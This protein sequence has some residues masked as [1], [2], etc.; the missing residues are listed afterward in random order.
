MNSIKTISS[1][2]N[3]YIKFIRSLRTKKSRNQSGMFYIEG[4]RLVGEA[5]DT[6][7]PLECVLFCP[8]LL[9]SDYGKDLVNKASS[10]NIELIEVTTE[11]FHYFSI[12]EG[13][14]GIA[15][16]GKQLWSDID[17]HSE[18]NGVWIALEN[19]QDP[20]NLGTIMRSLDGAGGKGVILIGETTDPFHPSA[21]RSSTG[22]IFSLP[23][24]KITNEDFKSWKERYG[25]YCVGTVCGNEF[26]FREVSYPKDMILVMGSEQKGLSQRLAGICNTLVSI[27]MTGRIDSLNLSNAASIVLFEIYTK[28]LEDD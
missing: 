7:Y 2:S 14:H 27:P 25:I 4:I 26:S 9:I 13:P 8:D 5:F 21:V 17:E 28:G 10:Q 24:V 22:S 15:A 11:V 1:K 19:I 23:V 16:V 12:K 20:G 3:S 18:I 6:K